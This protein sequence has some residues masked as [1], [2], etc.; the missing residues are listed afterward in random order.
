MIV[1]CPVGKLES[2]WVPT[3]SPKTINQSPNYTFLGLS[4]STTILLYS[5][6]HKSIDCI[7]RVTKAWCRLTCVLWLRCNDMLT[8]NHCSQETD[9]ESTPGYSRILLRELGPT[10]QLRI[11][12]VQLSLQWLGRCW[13]LN[14]GL[15]KLLARRD[16]IVSSNSKLY[17]ESSNRKLF[18]KITTEYFKIGKYWK[19]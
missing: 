7:T 9:H 16:L 12:G 13:P 11:T 15:E 5:L 18:R 17:R 19:E 4:L 2:S 14:S 6:N 3:R 1:S 8:I 10:S